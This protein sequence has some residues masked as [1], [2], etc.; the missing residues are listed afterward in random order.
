M[1]SLAGLSARREGEVVSC[2]Y[3]GFVVTPGCVDPYPATLTVTPNYK[4]A[5]SPFFVGFCPSRDKIPTA[6]KIMSDIHPPSS[7]THLADALS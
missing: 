6:F 3:G 5:G 2:N 1:T 4:D 7:R